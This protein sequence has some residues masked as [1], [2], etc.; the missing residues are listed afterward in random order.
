M[1]QDYYSLEEVMKKLAKSKSTVLRDAK[2]GLIPSEIEEGK[3]KGRR[4]PK[5]A[6]DVLAEIELE[7]R[8]RNKTP[9]LVFSPSTPNDLWAEV[10]IGKELYGEDDIVP[11][12]QLLKW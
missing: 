4:Y 11:F 12:K 7:K 6:I 3:K 8:S 9:H 2:A 10:S 1:E 5:E